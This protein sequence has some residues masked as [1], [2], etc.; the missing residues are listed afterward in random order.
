MIATLHS[1]RARGMDA[2]VGCAW[3]RFWAYC[4]FPPM[5]VVLL[6]FL[7]AALPCAH[8]SAC[9]AHCCSNLR[10][11]GLGLEQYC[12][13]TYYGGMPPHTPGQA[14]TDTVR[15]A[16]YHG[17]GGLVGDPKVF[18]CPSV[19]RRRGSSKTRC[20]Y[21]FFPRPAPGL[22]ANAILACDKPGNHSRGG[23]LLYKDLHIK[24]ARVDP[25][26]YL[27]WALAFAAGDRQAALL[28]PKQWGQKRG[29]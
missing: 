22:P 24:F 16:L 2:W 27:E 1:K 29:W 9:K 28:G 25:D 21:L 7:L 23:A 20:D 11:I 14:Y 13:P 15:Q 3:H 4:V 8:E 12:A 6:G 26:L 5:G 18:E 10:Q 17:G 19:T